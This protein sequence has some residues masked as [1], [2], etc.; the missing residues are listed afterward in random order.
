VAAGIAGASLASEIVLLPVSAL[1]FNRV[2]LAGLVLNLGAV[3]L[4]AV[5]QIAASLTV[6][7]D[8][9]SGSSALPAVPGMVAA[10][11]A[12]GLVVTSH[13]VEWWPWL[14]LRVPA[15]H[16][17]VT[18][19]YLVAV[20]A[21]VAWMPVANAP[22]RR[23]IGRAAALV[24]VSVGLWILLA[25]HT[26]RWPWR[27]DGLL[28]IV[29]LDVGQGD[30]TLIEFPDGQRWLVDAGGLPG[31]GRFDVGARVVA[32]ALW[33]RGVGRLTSAARTRSSTISGPPS[34]RAC[35]SHPTGR[36]PP[37]VRAPRRAAA[38]GPRPRP[39][40]RGGSGRSRCGSGIPSLRT[41]SASASATMIRS[42]S[43]SATAKSR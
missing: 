25:P 26:W 32:P 33:W 7:G 23:T 18:A 13:V 5:V 9:A 37:F 31:G 30:A 3:P 29:A 19:L 39:A 10:V 17:V 43:S 16:W 38:H 24:A 21:V 28:K 2:T 41:G 15:P 1:F 20:V 22:H 11:A 12:R 34:P 8:A 42:C 35:R 40:R 36:W 6:A 4:M 14:A 27:A